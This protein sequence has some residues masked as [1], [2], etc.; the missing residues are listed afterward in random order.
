[1]RREYSCTCMALDPVARMLDAMGA[2]PEN[3]G[4]P[5]GT[6]LVCSRIAGHDGEHVACN[7]T[8]VIDLYIGD[9]H[10]VSERLPWGAF[11]TWGPGAW[12]G[13]ADPSLH[14][15][16]VDC[17]GNKFRVDTGDTNENNI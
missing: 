3:C 6:L 17:Y 9:W 8:R 5:V 10:G 4:A 14:T 11:V 1:M 12:L 7:R 2:E 15:P 16:S 13:G